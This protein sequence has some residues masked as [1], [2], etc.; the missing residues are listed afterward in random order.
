[1]LK[2]IKHYTYTEKF[3]NED[4]YGINDSFIFVLDGATGLSKQEWM[5][6][7]SDAFWFVNEIKKALLEQWNDYP[8]P[9]LLLKQTCK[10]L[11]TDYQ[12]VCNLP[13]SLSAMP[14]ACLSLF[15]EN[16]DD[17]HYYGLGDCYGIIEFTDGHIEIFSDPIL[18]QLDQ[19][20]L[21]QM[22]A[23][24]EEKK[25]P[26]FEARSS[27]QQIL[28]QNR[29]LRNQP[30]G[31]HAL[32]LTW[33]DLEIIPT[34]TWKKKDVHR[35][36]CASDGFYEIMHYDLLK[37]AEDLFNHI[38]LDSDDLIKKLYQAQEDD[39]QALLCPRFKLRDDCTFV[40]AEVN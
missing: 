33:S 6:P 34:L 5:H 7:Q 20:A 29:L 14:S 39:S 28:I 40:Y 17:L 31:Y 4:A 11:Y 1:M 35:I 36:L 25:I 24:S 10:K 21:K 22:R 13:T 37:N 32:D 2:N 9:L 8:S 38:S 19:N 30:N 27:I 18:E 3:V 15:Y 16:G 12:N 26:F 23:I